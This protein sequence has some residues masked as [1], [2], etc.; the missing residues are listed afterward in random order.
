MVL[1]VITQLGIFVFC[2]AAVWLANDPRP[3][4]NR[5]ASISGL[6]A[7]PFWY[8]EAWQHAQWGIFAA[9]IIYNAAWARGFYHGWIK[10]A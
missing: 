9:T 1:L 8:V 10:K 3:R 4:V 5:W 7:Q 2:V 6:I